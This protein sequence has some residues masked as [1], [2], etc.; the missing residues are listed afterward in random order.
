M[1][2]NKNALIRYQ[3]LDRCFRNTGRMFFWQDL[4]KECNSALASANYDSDGIQKRQLYDDIR[5][6]ESEE[7][8][9]I[10]LRKLKFGRKVYYRYADPSFSINNQPLNASEAEQL[11]SALQILSRFSGLPHFEWINEMIP[12][13]ESKLGAVAREREIMSFQSNVDL[14]GFHHIT[15]LFNAIVNQR[16]LQVS[17][18]DFKSREPYNVN[19]H[20]YFLKQFNDRW[21]AFGLNAEFEISNWNM[22]VDRIQSITETDDQYKLSNIDWE[23]YFYDIVGVTRLLDDEPCE[24]TLRFVPSVAPYIT[25]KPI[26][27][28]QRSRLSEDGLEVKI[29]VILNYEL[30]SLLLSFG[31]RVEVLSPASLRKKVGDRL[32]HATKTYQ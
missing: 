7:G 21:F 16:V 3:T 2:V 12:S 4:L 24:V 17:Y 32:F 1:A 9:S 14:K 26:H 10:D 6:M 19:F 18:Q 13:V 28:S 11:K 20:P 22:P 31:D 15:P 5:F 27:P 29:K 25:T 30:E 23:M 8:W